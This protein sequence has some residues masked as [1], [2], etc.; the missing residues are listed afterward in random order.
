MSV[1]ISTDLMRANIKHR[2]GRE[3]FAP[4]VKMTT[5]RMILAVTAAERNWHLR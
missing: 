1:A 4:V 3:T 5:V 2:L